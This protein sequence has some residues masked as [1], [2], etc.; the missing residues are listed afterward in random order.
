AVGHETSQESSDEC[1]ADAVTDLGRVTTDFAHRDHDTKHGRYDSEPR[2]RVASDCD[3]VGGVHGLVV[4]AL[5]VEVERRIEIVRVDCAR[6]DHL[7]GVG[8]EA[9]R[10]L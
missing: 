2:H 10:V 9:Y 4:I 3:G 5:K 6:D 1:G 8:E 7:R